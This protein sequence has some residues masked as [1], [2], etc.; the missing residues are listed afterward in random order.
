[1][2]MVYYRCPIC[3]FIHQVPEYWSGFSP[4]E[5]IEMMHFNLETKEMCSE[6]MLKLVKE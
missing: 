2:E 5:E 1:M 6:T 4:E 3:G